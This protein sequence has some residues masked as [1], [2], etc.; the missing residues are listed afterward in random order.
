MSSVLHSQYHACWCSGD[1][2]R[3]GISRHGIDLQSQTILS[4]ESQELTCWTVFKDYERCI[5]LSYHILDFVLQKKTG[6]TMEQT[7]MLPILYCQYHSCWCPRN[8]RSQGISRHGIDQISRNIPSL[9]SEEYWLPS[10]KP[11]SE[12]MLT[13]CLLD[14]LKQTS[15]KVEEKI[16][17]FLFNEM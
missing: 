10:T 15:V 9:A 11:S 13:Y 5:P 16:Q 14:S 6:F 3:Q 2:K 12:L 4:S 8:W 1:F 17:Q 7:Y